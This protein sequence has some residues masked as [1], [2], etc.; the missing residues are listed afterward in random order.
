M[1][2]LYV[3]FYAMMPDTCSDSFHEQQ[4][5]ETECLKYGS[6]C[7]GDLVLCPLLRL[8]PCYSPNPTLCC[9]TFTLV[10]RGTNNPICWLM[11][12]R[13]DSP[14]LTGIHRQIQ[15]V[16]SQDRF[17]IKFGSSCDYLLK[18]ELKVKAITFYFYF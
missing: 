9:Y 2:H 8:F 6:W 3:L 17:P 10:H 1:L 11:K 16:P 7:G 4:D 5:M 14:S 13:V 18:V 12:Q 15:E